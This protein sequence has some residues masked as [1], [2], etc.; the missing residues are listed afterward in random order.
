MDENTAKK[1]DGEKK[2][3]RLHSDKRLV[4]NSE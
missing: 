2:Y 1:L 4:D 3:S